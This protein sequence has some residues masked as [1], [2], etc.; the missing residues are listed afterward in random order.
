MND[1]ISTE[2]FMYTQILFLR[3]SMLS[4]ADQP[5][6]TIR[7]ADEF[8]LLNEKHPGIMTFGQ[9]AKA[10]C[11]QAEAYSDCGKWKEAV[12]IY[13]SLFRE[14]K[15]RCKNPYFGITMG[16]S[17]ALYE[18]GKYDEAIEIGNAAMES[19]RSYPGVHKYIALSHK[20]KGD[21]DEAK[22]TISKAILYE[23]HWNKDNLQKNK[24]LLRELNDL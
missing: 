12:T 8:L 9:V 15:Q 1:I 18:I 24:E 2:N 4:M 5:D 11:W 17:R 16:C 20:A 22:K 6:D 7:N 10:K 21:I 3:V 19:I 13:K 14:H 23:E